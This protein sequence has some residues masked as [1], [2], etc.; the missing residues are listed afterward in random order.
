MEGIKKKRVWAIVWKPGKLGSL[1]ACA[2]VEAS[3]FTSRSNALRAH[4]SV[5][6]NRVSQAS[7][8]TS[9]K[10]SGPVWMLQYLKL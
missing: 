7:R 5:C 9:K 1:V 6:G 8:Q 10:H 2:S 4:V 3:N